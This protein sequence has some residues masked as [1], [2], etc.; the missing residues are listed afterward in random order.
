MKN[1]NIEII[2]KYIPNI[3]NFP[4]PGIQFKD[5]TPLISHHSAFKATI[6]ELNKLASKYKY[7]VIVAPESRGFWFGIPLAYTNKIPFVPA[8]KKGKLP[9]ETVSINYS[10]EY[11]QATIQIHKAD[12]KPGMRVL[13]VDDLIAT[14]GTIEAIVKLLRKMKAI[15]VAAIFIVELSELNGRKLLMKQRVPVETVLKLSGK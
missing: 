8:R 6:T 9:R 13:I 7:D 1:I 14:G 3:P 5:V 2:K 10:I 4:I 11:G 15:P 12:I